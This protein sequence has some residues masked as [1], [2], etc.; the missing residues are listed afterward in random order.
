M[1]PCG[2]QVRSPR[3]GVRARVDGYAAADAA[4][5]DDA[6]SAGAAQAVLDRRSA[7][8]PFAVGGYVIGA[9]ALVAA[10]SL[11]AVAVGGD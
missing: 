5:V 11:V 4:G 3:P 1:H 8:A 10:A 6:T 7:L 9:V 2:A